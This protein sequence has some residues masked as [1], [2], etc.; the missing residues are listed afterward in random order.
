MAK[1]LDKGGGLD[2]Q[3]KSVAAAIASEDGSILEAEFGMTIEQI[4][5]LKKW[6]LDMPGLHS[7]YGINL[8]S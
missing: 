2:I 3:K 6:L 8:S 7:K 5:Q 1:E 4:Y